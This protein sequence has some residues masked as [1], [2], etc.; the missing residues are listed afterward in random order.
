MM[1]RRDFI[2]ASIVGGIGGVAAVR[3][4]LWAV[5]AGP[6]VY[7]ASGEAANAVRRV[8]DGLGGISRFVQPGMVVAL[9]PNISFPNPAGWSTTTSPEVL[10][11]VVEVC[12]D[13]GA[14]R[15]LIVENPMQSDGEKNLERS[16]LQAAIHEDDIVG[17]MIIKEE[18]KYQAVE[19]LGAAVL[20]TV[21]VAKVIFRAD[22]FINIPVA[23]S[24]RE[25]S[26]SLG[27]KNLMGLIW[28]RK[29]F[30]EQLDLHRAIAD[31]SLVFR[32]DLTIMDAT[33]GLLTNGPEGPG[34]V[35]N[36]GKVIA[37]VD[38]LA[39][40]AVT[41]MQA[42]W[43][44]MSMMPGDVLH[45]RYAQELGAG[46]INPEQILQMDLGG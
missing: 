8:V 30:H 29:V 13:A 16:G 4:G 45:L 24:H 43:N 46:T 5:D 32:P 25:T 39:V 7:L 28:D 41:V 21:Q 37:G 26:V 23:K 38:P 35:G 18:R 17:F 22:C 10:K 1:K 2:K 12:R 40:D 9:K 42:P 19:A 36:I 6:R 34:R 27:L 44:R 15:I 33:R 20:G 14:K 3:G 11:G 31:L